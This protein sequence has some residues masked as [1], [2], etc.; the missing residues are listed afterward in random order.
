M[1]PNFFA[2][3]RQHA[4]SLTALRDGVLAF[5]VVLA[6]AALTGYAVYVRASEGLKQEVQSYLYSLAGTASELTDGDLHQLITRPEDKHNETYE[7]VRAPYFK[8]LRA[9]PNIAFIYTVIEQEGK[10]YFILD[11][12][13]LKPGEKDDTSDVMEEY[14]DATDR[15][16]EALRTRSRLVEDEA[17]T[18]E[19]GTFLS[20]YAPIYNSKKQFVGIVGADI[21]L[22][23]YLA[24]LAKIKQAL[25]IGMGIAGLASILAGAGVW[26]VRRNAL[27]AAELNRQQQAR[28]TAME[29]A[30]KEEHER[31]KTETEK[32]KREAMHSLADSFECSV[33]G[34]VSRLAESADAMQQNAEAMTSISADTK[35]RSSQVAAASQEAVQISMEVSTAADE[36]YAS[37]RE[38]STQ[39]LKSNQIA[40]SASTQAQT[41][42]RAIESLAEKSGHIG[43]IIQLIT[44]IAAQI[45]LL[46]L[47][48]TIEAARAGEM[49]KG[50]AVVAGEVKT[51]ASQVAKATHDITEQIAEMQAATNGSVSA[52]MDI[53]GIISQVSNSTETVAAAVEEQSAVTSSIAQNISIS[54]QG[55]QKISQ[56]IEGVQQGA[57]RTGE[58]A[59]HVLESAR[60][61][62]KQ[63]QL[64]AEK[65]NHFLES[66][67]G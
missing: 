7:K 43:E 54:S 32:A 21:R 18:D 60:D 11:S 59:Q 50:F 67:R 56:H 10:I 14:T 39:T 38:I 52:V 44:S 53:I 15:M 23:D 42:K 17:Y 48:A 25:M 62:G 13:I 24:H 40:G 35:Q 6:V 51:L 55:A 41:A 36:L 9:N 30:Q 1:K 61:L 22:T 16:K 12:K 47:N 4:A 33:K 19:W 29:A 64:L 49:G 58:N 20:G 66:I 5:V 57:E 2:G 34:V 63:S 26:W 3:I 65:V 37:I 8:L 31:Q 28:M 45:N 27:Q 46:A